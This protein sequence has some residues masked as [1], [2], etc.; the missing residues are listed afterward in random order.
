MV[1]DKII[2]IITPTYNGNRNTTDKYRTFYILS[3]L[4]L[5]HIYDKSG[6]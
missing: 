1:A 5:E 2:F 6:K 4:T 3:M